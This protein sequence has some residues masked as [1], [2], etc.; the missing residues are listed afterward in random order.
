MN[1]LNGERHERLVASPGDAVWWHDGLLLEAAHFQQLCQRQ[2]QLL[3]YHLRSAMPYA[4]GVR[5]MQ[6]ADKYLSNNLFSITSLEAIMPDGLVVSHQDG[7]DKLEF[8][9]TADL[10]AQL[11]ASRQSATICLA[12]PVNDTI[13]DADDSARYVPVATASGASGVAHVRPRLRLALA[14]DLE[15]QAND[16][17]LPLARVSVRLGK[18]EL[19]HFLPPLLDIDVAPSWVDGSSLYEQSMELVNRMQRAANYLGEASRK[20]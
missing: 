5:Q 16:A 14:S 13:A 7:A 11:A 4:W 17:V 12:V 19:V 8:P 10:H 6:I 18:F 15:K 1:E 3:T 9:L 20:R 2:E